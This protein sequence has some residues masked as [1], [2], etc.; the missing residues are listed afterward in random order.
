M[1]PVTLARQGKCG[2]RVDGREADAQVWWA[3]LFFDEDT[4]TGH[5]S[6]DGKKVVLKGWW[7]PSKHLRPTVAD[8][9]ETELWDAG[10]GGMQLQVGSGE[11]PD[12]LF[13]WINGDDVAGYRRRE[14]G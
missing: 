5:A 12:V 6:L 1:K 14:G 7:G 11:R 8:L 9:S 2:E 13:A 3:V 4:V 10:A